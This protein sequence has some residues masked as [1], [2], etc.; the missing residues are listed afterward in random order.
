MT[1][2]VTSL[3]HSERH[4]NEAASRMRQAGIP[5]SAIDIWTTPH[6]LAPLLEDLGVSRTD[7][8]AYAE[9]VIRG[10]TVVIVKCDASEVETAVGILDQEGVLDLDE[11]QA[12]WRSEGW[13]GPPEQ[14]SELAGSSA[15][16]RATSETEPAEVIIQGRIRIQSVR[17]EPPPQE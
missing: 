7:A 14:A 6:N 16:A 9:G 10:G 1:K 8:H 17:V 5:A 13:E 2:T 15:P 4:A 3:F 11:Q 12:A